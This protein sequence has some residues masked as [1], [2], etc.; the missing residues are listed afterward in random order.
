MKRLVTRAPARL[1]DRISE[2][3][4]ALIIRRYS[5]SFRLASFLLVDPVRTHVRNIYALVRVADE[6][7]DDPDPS[8]DAETRLHLLDSLQDDVRRSIHTGHSANPV[9]HSFART[10]I[11]AGIGE[12]LITPFFTSMRTDLNTATHTQGSLNEYIHG[13]AEVVGLMC[14][15]VFLTD[16][17]TTASQTYE[18]LAPG[19][20][21][22]GAAFQKINFLRDLA[23]DYDTLHRVYLPSIDVN[24]FTDADRDRILDD[25]ARDLDAA[26]E[27][28]PYL[29]HSS[30]RAVRAAHATFTDLADALRGTPSSRIRTTRVRVPNWKKIQRLITSAY[31]GRW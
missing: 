12:D 15:R 8:M 1:Y 14:L 3:T 5:T 24:S 27:V 21:R 2:E 28:I 19:A 10:A 17:S 6:L 16:A 7:V 23:D 26:A 13:S 29:P 25:I 4:S 9:V 11:T 22:L 30:R 20:R 31:L 18:E